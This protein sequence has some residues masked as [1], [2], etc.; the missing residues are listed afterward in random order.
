MKT[1]AYACA[2]ALLLA[3][4]SQSPPPKVATAHVSPAPGSRDALLQKDNLFFLNKDGKEIASGWLQLPHPLPS[5][6]QKV[7]GAW[8]LSRSDRPFPAGS[9][10]DGVYEATKVGTDLFINLNPSVNDA[11]VTLSGK[12]S[13]DV[14]AGTWYHATFAGAERMGTFRIEA[15]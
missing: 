4:C 5:G 3:G 11:N 6:D 15:P 10:S 7:L 2:F 9:I 13:N 1:F 14:M 12:V 8:R